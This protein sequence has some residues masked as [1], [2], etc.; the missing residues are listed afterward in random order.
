MRYKAYRK[1]GNPD[2]LSEAFKQW[3]LSQH[4]E[5]KWDML[6]TC[7]QKR[8]VWLFS[9]LVELFTTTEEQKGG[10]P[11]KQLRLRYIAL[12]TTEKEQ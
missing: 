11:P 8:H 6:D 12:Q 9:R 7:H 5:L 3:V 4:D 10:L 2:E 1:M